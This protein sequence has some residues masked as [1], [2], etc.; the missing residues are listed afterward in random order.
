MKI[1]RF[2][3][4]NGPAYGVIEGDGIR[5][6]AGTPWPEIRFSGRIFP[7]NPDGL[8]STSPGE[9]RKS[10]VENSM[11]RLLAP[12]VP[13]VVW[14]IGLNYRAH[15]AELGN[16]IPEEPLAFLK[17][18]T[19]VIGP[20]DDIVIPEMAPDAVDYECELAVVIGRPCKNVSEADALDYVLGYTC[21]NDV[22]ARDCQYLRDKQWAR[23][24]GFET[25]CPLGPWIE[26][27]LDPDHAALATVLNGKTMQNSSTADM[28]FSVRQLIR[29]SSRIGTLLPGTVILTGTPPGV[30]YGRNP[31]VHLHPGDTVEI[32]VA[33]IGTLR[34]GVRQA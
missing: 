17:P 31:R 27:E 34:N 26:T 18:S 11:P 8:Y 9:N 24:K 21:A 23:A 13:P 4:E 7:F 19:S 12:V 16:S 3:T 25:F 20:G 28:I 10:K 6:L 32:T 1:A 29:H 14:A 22:T 30:G 2:A 15:A 33:G 5:E